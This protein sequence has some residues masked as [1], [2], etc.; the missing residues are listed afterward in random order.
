[1]MSQRSK[2]EVLER[3]RAR[4][5]KASK[6]E[7]QI[8]LDELT[9]TT[10]YNR[11]YAIRVLRH[12][13]RSKGLKK[14]GRK[15]RYT[16][17]TIQILEQLWEMG[18]R[19][20]SKRLHP[21][22]PEWIR[23]LEECG[24]IS[25]THEVKA[26]LLSMSRSTIDRRLQ[27]ARI[28]E[29]K[30]GLS[31]T[32]PGALLKRQI[33]V[34]IYTPWDEQQPGFLEIDLVAHCGETTAGNYLNT[35][36]ATDL[37]T[38]WT[39]CLALPNKTQTATFLA[40]K[41]LQERLPFPLLGLDSDNGSEFINDMLYRFCLDQ[42]ITFTRCRPYRKNDQA[43]VEQKNWSVVRHTVGYD[44]FETQAEL[45][46]LSSIYADLRLF[47]NFFQPVEKLISSTTI[48]G[49]KHKQYDQAKTPY[50]RVLEDPRVDE[51]Y[52]TQ[53]RILYNSLNPVTI[54]E[55]LIEKTARMLKIA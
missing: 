13:R 34:R 38:G 54:R 37:A 27:P 9:A 17:E 18:G 2:K 19:L 35:L 24:E 52:K 22:L 10:G 43:H 6:A 1:M 26:Q 55:A 51:K 42:Q 32:K 48:N 49:V 23:K 4:Y 11:K 25:L 45:D 36:T 30:R 46:L 44:R 53:L 50:Q 41:K 31:T 14:A 40:I 39:E 29:K 47:V 28:K 21:F 3:I 8:I 12:P 20:C 7:K 15:R 33:P 16:G 5:L